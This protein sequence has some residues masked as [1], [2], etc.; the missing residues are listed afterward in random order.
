M[1]EAE[2]SLEK[3][4]SLEYNGRPEFERKRHLEE[5][6]TSS[7]LKD[8]VRPLETDE[9]QEAINQIFKDLAKTYLKGS[10][11]QQ[12]IRNM[13]PA[14]FIPIELG[15]ETVSNSAR[16]QYPEQSRSG[17]IVTYSMYC[18]S[19]DRLLDK[20]NKLKTN[21]TTI[22]IPASIQGQTRKYNKD[23]TGSGDELGN[24]LEEFLAENGIA[25]TILC[26]FASTVFQGGMFG[27]LV[28]EEGAKAGWAANVIAGIALLLEIGLKAY[29]IIEM[30]KKAKVHTPLI[31]DQ[32]NTLANDPAARAAA[33][34]KIGI[35]QADLKSTT[36]ASDSQEIVNYVS[37]YYQRYGGFVGPNSHLTIDHWLAYSSV[38]KNQQVI[39]SSLNTA[40][41]FSDDFLN[42]RNQE[43][44]QPIDQSEN[45]KKTSNMFVQL[46][47]ATKALRE[48]SNNA[49]DDI[50]DALQYQLTDQDLC[51][52]VQVFGANYD[53]G[54]LKTIASILRVLAVDLSG[55]LIKLDNIMRRF[56]A[57]IFQAAVFELTAQ[58]NEFYCKV[59]KKLT[60]LFTMDIEGAEACGGLLTIGLALIQSVR[61]LF[62]MV[63]D[64][65]SEISAIIGEYGLPNL[66]GWSIKGQGEWINIAERRHL[67]GIARALE[68][69]ATRLDLAKSCERPSASAAGGVSFTLEEVDTTGAAVLSIIEKTDPTLKLDPKDEQKYFSNRKPRS[70][71]R[72][73]FSFGIKNEQNI[74]ESNKS[75]NCGD[76]TS[77]QQ[78]ENLIQSFRSA[79]AK[80]DE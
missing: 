14:Q 1:E 59:L 11:L 41:T 73:K 18:N 35:T 72:L 54:M 45:P 9:R 74:S 4:S 53:T 38:A 60:K 71:E 40:D 29:T 69:I 52:L 64:M 75:T 49:Y 58:L 33:L 39:R 67:I 50:M 8:L 26:M 43:T 61:A 19:I 13:D 6:G 36:E 62:K 42:I 20:Q 30:L 12:A 55:E 78:I 34:E 46:A 76:T 44:P 51:C 66:G 77:A 56:L 22:S 7:A 2:A 37:E 5:T 25:G 27:S 65:I 23:M 16:R 3:M 32:T 80:A 48:R 47:G 57:N 70:S 15:A 17:T 24:I 31:E 79:L 63:E 10:K 68:V 28:V 21:Y